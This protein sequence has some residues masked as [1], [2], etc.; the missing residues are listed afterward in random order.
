MISYSNEYIRILYQIMSILIVFQLFNVSICA[1]STNSNIFFC[2][3]ANLHGVA[4]GTLLRFEVIFISSIAY[5]RTR[6]HIKINIR[7]YMFIMKMQ[8]VDEKRLWRKSAFL[9]FFVADMHCGYE[10]ML[11]C[12]CK[13]SIMCASRVYYAWYAHRYNALLLYTHYV[14]CTV[15]I[16]YKS[17]EET[18]KISSSAGTLLENVFQK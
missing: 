6:I 7:E 3:N 17:S 12:K 13:K 16:S 10:M 2:F 8:V 1:H 11:H 9:L 4:N 14:L 15:E 5:T 18:D